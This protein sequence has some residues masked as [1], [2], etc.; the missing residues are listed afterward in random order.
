MNKQLSA[1]QQG[2]LEAKINGATPYEIISLMLDEVF[3]SLNQIK[4]LEKNGDPAVKISRQNEL[5]N[6]V[7]MIVMSLAGAVDKKAYPELAENLILL[8]DYCNTR[9]LDYIE[10][11]DVAILTDVEVV[12]GKIKDGWNAIAPV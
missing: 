4:V 3:K 8:Y 9:I 10:V 6:K 5:A 7:H 1:Y 12:M 11:R 2:D